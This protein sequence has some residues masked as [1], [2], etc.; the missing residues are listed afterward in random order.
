MTAPV[1]KLACKLADGD[2]L[3]HKYV[4]VRV[5]TTRP[6][7][8]TYTAVPYQ[9]DPRVGDGHTMVEWNGTPYAVI[10][11]GAVC[12]YDAPGCVRVSLCEAHRDALRAVQRRV[13]TGGR[14][15][16][17]RGTALSLLLGTGPFA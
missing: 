8:A 10:P 2:W 7:G 5:I 17:P 16:I 3:F 13:S 11:A 12:E 9:T 4:C 15:T 6:V 1:V 14:D